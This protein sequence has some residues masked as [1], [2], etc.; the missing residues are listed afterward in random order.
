[1][2]METVANLI[3]SVS[4]RHTDAY[5]AAKAREAA[6]IR[7]YRICF[8]DVGGLLTPERARTL[9]PVVLESAGDIPVE[10]HAHC[11]SGQAPLCYLEGVKLGI[12]V[13]HTA[14]P[15]LANGSSQPSIFNVAHNLRA[16]GYAP[17]VDEK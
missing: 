15:P 9:I 10:F 11:N 2:G 3:Y 5:Y 7:P 8:K 12:R 4:P 1:H 6:A 14:V 16:L 17:A 13:L